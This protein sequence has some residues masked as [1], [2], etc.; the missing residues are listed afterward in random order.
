M[1]DTKEK[2]LEYQVIALSLREP[3]AI[4]SFAKSLP[5]EAMGLNG[6]GLMNFYDSL[7]DFHNKT[8]I[9]PID[10]LVFRS[11]L[12]TETVLYDALGGAS[13]VAAFIET[14]LSL[15]LASYENV[16]AVLSY[17]YNKRRQMDFLQELQGLLTQKTVNTA[18]DNQRINYL[19]DQIRVLEKDLAYDPLSTV[20]TAADMAT[21]D[22]SIFDLPDFLPTQFDALNEAMGYTKNG[23]FC[24]GAVHAVI[25]ASGLGKS[26]FCKSLCNHWADQGHTVLYV[27]Y[28]EARKHW[29]RILFTQITKRNV[30]EGIPREDREHLLD[31]F[32]NKMTE[33]GNRFMVRHDP[34]TQYFDD[35][36][37][38]LRDIIGHNENI[39]DVVVIDTIQ[40]M[41]TKGKGQQRWG[42]FEEIMVRLEKLAK[43]MNA[44][45]IVTS[46][47][48]SNRMK[49][50]REVVQQSDVGGSL[51]IIQKCSVTIF[52]TAK[53]LATGDISEDPNIMQLQIPK[54]RITGTSFML[55]PPLVR[56]DDATKSYQSFDIPKG[57][58]YDAQIHIDDFE[59]YN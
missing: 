18:E 9:D 49:E 55:N 27:N 54:N 1:E 21:Y 28:E 26:T 5:R 20:T 10:P 33:W 7:V 45:F 19:T 11:W 39:P 8:G 40:S 3:G 32:R 44:V 34:E 4:S 22:E 48:N 25:A 52:L 14:M 2:P 24:K 58:E 6:Q 29:E 31:I 23:G 41:F 38:W 36:E 15:E 16:Q 43:D 51:T 17:R 37:R 56:Y 13:I 59:G 46:Q 53:Q 42:Q 57:P 12:E 30:Y 35:L 50:K 47:E